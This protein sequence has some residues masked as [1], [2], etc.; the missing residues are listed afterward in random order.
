MI[1]TLLVFI[2]LLGILV[3]VHELGHFLAAKR[4]GVRVDEFAFGFKPRLLSKKIGQTTYAINAI[5]LGGYVKLYGEKETETGRESFRSK[6]A[7]WKFIIFIAG[8]TMNL[9]LAWLILTILFSVGFNPL[10]PGV[11]ANPLVDSRQEV[12]IDE[13]A[14]GSPAEQAGLKKGERIESVNDRQMATVGEFIVT[15]DQLA[16]EDIVLGVRDPLEGTSRQVELTPRQNPPEGE[17][18]LGVVVSSSGEVRTSLLKAPVAS[19]IEVGRIIGL[20]AAGFAGFVKDLV[21]KQEVSEN[22]TGIVG[23]GALT[24]IARRLGVDYL[25]QLLAIVSIGLAVV[26]LVPILPLDGGHVVALAY[27][28]LAGRPLSERHF[29]TFAAV[30]LAMVLGIFLVVTYKD[31]VRFNVID[32]I[33]NAFQ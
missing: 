1:I 5:P 14:P 9:V 25:A 8:S 32:R 17:G 20:S 29:N 15:V 21:V 31:I 28:K 33:L 22:V 13:I 2:L 11:A 10:T 16:G 19:V 3:F 6:S 30:G 26:N 24:G 18:R 23:A 12:L 4:A 7:S 27:E